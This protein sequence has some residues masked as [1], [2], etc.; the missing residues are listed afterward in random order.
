MNTHLPLMRRQWKNSTIQLFAILLANGTAIE[1]HYT[2]N[3]SGQ[4]IFSRLFNLEIRTKG[5]PTWK[6]EQKASPPA[7]YFLSAPVWCKG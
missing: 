4:V 2:A 5:L 3:K 6:T 7:F 1:P